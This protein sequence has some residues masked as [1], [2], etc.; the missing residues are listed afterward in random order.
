M[1]HLLEGLWYIKCI[2]GGKS[3][4]KILLRWIKL[5]WCDGGRRWRIYS[6]HLSLIEMFSYVHGDSVSWGFLLSEHSGVFLCSQAQAEERGISTNR[7]SLLLAVIGIANLVGRIILGYISDKPWINRL[8]V[9]NV[10]LTICGFGECRNR[11]CCFF[12]LTKSSECIPVWEAN[13]SLASNNL[14]RRFWNQNIHIV[15]TRAHLWS[16]FWAKW[17]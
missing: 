10:C 1:E 4:L 16:L 7:A 2:R 14:A 3:L 6:W 12:R 13:C 5:G 15:F 17:I 9:Y 8:M 11:L